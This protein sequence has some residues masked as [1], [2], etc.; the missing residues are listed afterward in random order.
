M[1]VIIE[2]RKEESLNQKA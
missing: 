1:Q 2:D